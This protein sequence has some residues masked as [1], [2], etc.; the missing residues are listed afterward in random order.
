MEIKNA[1]ISS[2]SI[3][4][5]DRGFL[6][7]HLHLDYGDSGQSFG[8]YILYLSK[9]Y[10][11]H[12]ASINYAG[13][14]IF[15]CMQIAGVTAWDKIVGKTIRVKAEHIQVHA[16]GHIVKDDWFDPAKDFEM[17]KSFSVKAID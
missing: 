2:V 12:S 16:I 8:G 14:F 13:H 7:A 6:T 3:D 4:D 9:E 11:N 5:G 1:L 10:T 17:L 15:R